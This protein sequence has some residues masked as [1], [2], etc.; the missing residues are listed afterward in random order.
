MAKS[1]KPAEV[2]PPGEFIREELQARRWTQAD[3]ARIL[4]RPLQVVNQ[5]INGKTRITVETAKEIGLALG[6]G[7]ELWLNLENQYRLNTTAEPDQAIA[8]RAKN[9]AA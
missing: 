9:M 2:F 1:G 4:G 7:P 6:T 5:I 3:F 8:R